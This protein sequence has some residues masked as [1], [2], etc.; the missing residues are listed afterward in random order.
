VPIARLVDPTASILSPRGKVNEGG[1]NRFFRRFSEGVFDLED[2]S[3]QT[4]D[5]ADFLI[6]AASRFRF[7]PGNIIALGFSN[8]ANIA[9]SLMLQKPQ[10]LAGAILLRGMVPFEPAKPIDLKGKRAFLVNG[11]QDPIIPVENA[12]RLA[13]IL[14]EGGAD[15]EQVML[16][17]GHNMTKE[18]VLLAKDWLL[19]PVSK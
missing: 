2:L 10:V 4:E 11:N 15:V 9:T 6:N 3:E 5:L 13:A 7:E 12:Q 1:A 14:R 19:A 16:E 17:T 18:E 8:G